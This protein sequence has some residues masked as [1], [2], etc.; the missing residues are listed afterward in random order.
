LVRELYPPDQPFEV[1]GKTMQWYTKEVSW[2]YYNNRTKQEDCHELLISNHPIQRYPR[3]RWGDL[4]QFTKT[5]TDPLAIEGPDPE[6][7]DSL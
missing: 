3:T 7:E 4:T 2:A 5:A 1:N 6:E